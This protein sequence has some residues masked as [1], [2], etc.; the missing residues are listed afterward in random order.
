MTLSQALNSAFPQYPESAH[1]KAASRMEKNMTAQHTP[2]PWGVSAQ[3]HG[4]SVWNV[5]DDEINPA[6]IGRPVANVV[7]GY[8]SVQIEE[9]NARLIAAA[10][11][12][13]E[14]LEAICK[15]ATECEM[16]GEPSTVDGIGWDDILKA[17]ATIAKA[18]K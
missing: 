11:D 9:A 7:G 6:C 18:R 10:P 16:H 15:H 5:V 1:R 8:D 14:A 13:L 3:P 2:G 4:Y 12:L 17:R